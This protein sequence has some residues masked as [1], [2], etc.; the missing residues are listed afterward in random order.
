VPTPFNSLLWRVVVLTD[1]GHLEGLDSLLIDEG[2][3]RFTAYPSD[4]R[5][6]EEAG[7]IRAVQRLEWFADGFIKADVVSG[8]LVISDLRM[9]QGPKFVFRHAVA[10]RGDREWVP[11][12]PVQLRTLFSAEEISA[13]WARLANP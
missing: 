3:M 6:L 13:V 12:D 5:A 10:I 11:I 8:Q 9:G 1:E 2:R 7:D 4:R